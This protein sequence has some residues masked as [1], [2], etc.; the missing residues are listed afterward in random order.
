[1]GL[2]ACGSDKSDPQEPPAPEVIG[3]HVPSPDWRDQIIYFLM[4]DRFNDGDR[5]N[6]DQG[7]GEYD[8]RS[9]KKFSGGDLAGVEQKID[10]IQGLGATAVWTTPPVANQWWDPAQNYGGYHGYWARDLQKVDEHFGDLKSYQALAK[11]LHAKGMYLIQDVVVNHL[12][13]FFTYSGTYDPAN[14]CQG[15]ELIPGALAAGQSLPA[16]LAQND[17]NNSSN[18]NAAITGRRRSRITTTALRS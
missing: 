15:F 12:G 3:S 8:P 6:N 5:A 18:F 9:E 7:T 16:P 4:I 17:C 10:Y 11:S 1:M 13:N 14:P 2:S